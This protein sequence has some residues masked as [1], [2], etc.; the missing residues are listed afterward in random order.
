M[1]LNPGNRHGFG[2]QLEQQVL[3]RLEA[4]QRWMEVLESRPEMQT[5]VDESV[6]ALREV[7]TG[8]LTQ[9]PPTLG[10]K[11]GGVWNSPEGMGCA[12]AA[13][14]ETRHRFYGLSGAVEIPI[15]LSPDPEA[16][17]SLEPDPRRVTSLWQ[18]A[19]PT[20]VDDD[21]SAEQPVS[22]LGNSGVA[23]RPGVPASAS[24]PNGMRGGAPADASARATRGHI[25]LNPNAR[26]GEVVEL[27]TRDNASRDA[28]PIE[29]APIES[30]AA[31][32]GSFLI[33]FA[34]IAE[35]SQPSRS[36]GSYRL[37]RE[38]NDLSQ[39]VEARLLGVLSG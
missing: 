38:D 19:L 34:E 13:P 27:P 11:N 6:D 4:L 24:S 22:L 8:M 32:S 39:Q 2:R 3:R 12:D 5:L 7:L 29:V 20:L 33:P 26:L 36:S 30:I 10:Q 9:E 14:S 16:E 35:N 1:E 23:F 18:S 37:N 17:R 25:P 28:A 31:L 21:E 15:E